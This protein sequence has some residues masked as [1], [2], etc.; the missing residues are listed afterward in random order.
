M[1]TWIKKVWR[2]ES[3]I[4]G[5]WACRFAPVGVVLEPADTDILRATFFV[6]ALIILFGF[7][8]Y[9]MAQAWRTNGW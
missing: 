1:K 3:F 9:A 4:L 5:W 8:A 6:E 7:A 2:L